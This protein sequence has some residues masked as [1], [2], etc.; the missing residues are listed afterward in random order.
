MTTTKYWGCDLIIV[1][2]ADTSAMLS[3]LVS[4]ETGA[5]LFIMVITTIILN[6]ATRF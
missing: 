1:S 3:S 6:K 2:L 5:N 4:S